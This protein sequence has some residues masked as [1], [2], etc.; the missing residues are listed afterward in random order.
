MATSC[1]GFEASGEGEHHFAHEPTKLAARQDRQVE[2][3]PDPSPAPAASHEMQDGIPR[4]S[5]S[6]SLPPGRLDPPNSS[7]RTPNVANGPPQGLSQSN[8]PSLSSGGFRCARAHFRTAHEP[9][10][11]H[12]SVRRVS[13]TLLSR[14]DAGPLP[15]RHFVIAGARHVQESANS[16]PAGLQ[17]EKNY[18]PCWSSANLKAFSLHNSLLFIIFLG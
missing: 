14:T 10:A 18:V 2:R 6:F 8:P 1:K 9:S 11:E 17:P 15:W 7:H 13:R 4:R 16:L 5:L 12:A 3:K